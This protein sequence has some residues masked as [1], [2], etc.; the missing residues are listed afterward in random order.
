[1][2]QIKFLSPTVGEITGDASIEAL[3]G[4]ALVG[5]YNELA[6]DSVKRFG[7]RKTGL[8]RTKKAFQVWKSQQKEAGPRPDVADPE[9]HRS[10]R[11]DSL[12]GKVIEMA[13]KAG[14][15]KFSDL[16]SATKWE[17]AELRAAI[18]RIETYNGLTVTKTGE[19]DEEVIVVA[20]VIRTR[21]PFAFDPKKE[22][23][24]ARE[25]TKRSKV[26]A[27]LT[28]KEGA[29][30]DEVKGET[31]WDNRTAYEGIR[32]I[33]GY[34]GYGLKETPEGKIFAFAKAA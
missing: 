10:Y 28:R 5:L 20:G 2:S 11:P 1:M 23:R 18:S 3:Q 14:G 34:L 4:T 33:H 27:L 6:N 19:G 30:F 22:Q 25:G 12:R 8:A 21:K 16:L 13:S 26:L 32:L 15:A 29:T 9:E 24:D 31:G 17:P 7:D